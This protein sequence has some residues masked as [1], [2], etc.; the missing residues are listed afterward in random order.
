MTILLVCGGCG[1]NFHQ[2]SMSPI[3]AN[4]IDRKLIIVSMSML[5]GSMNQNMVIIR[6]QLLFFNVDATF[7]VLLLHF[8]S[9]SLSFN[10]AQ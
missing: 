6:C 10:M 8:S 3:S 7:S 5:S 9:K 1:S 2:F 4:N